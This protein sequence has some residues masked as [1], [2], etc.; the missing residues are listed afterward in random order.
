MYSHTHSFC[1]CLNCSPTKHDRGTSHTHHVLIQE[2]VN[3]PV[4]LTN[5]LHTLSVSNT[6]LKLSICSFPTQISDPWRA[7][8]ITLLFNI[9][10]KL[11]RSE[12]DSCHT[13]TVSSYR[14]CQLFVHSSFIL[15]LIITGLTRLCICCHFFRFEK[16]QISKPN[17]LGDFEVK[18]VYI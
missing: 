15:G 7:H 8:R 5:D 3:Q 12:L 18:L 14:M 1:S 9:S 13:Y 11:I 16:F 6:Q 10:T 4:L 2:P 17:N